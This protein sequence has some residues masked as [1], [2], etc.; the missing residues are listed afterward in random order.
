MANRELYPLT[1][2]PVYRGYPWGGD[3]IA[4]TYGRRDAPAVAAESWEI[5]DRDGGMS[6][7]R[8]GPLAGVTLRELVARLGSRLLGRGTACRLC[9]A[10]AGNTLKIPKL[11]AVLR[12]IR[13]KDI[14]RRKK[15][16]EPVSR[17]A[18][19]YNLTQRRV[20]QILAEHAH[21]A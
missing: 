13:K 1:F 4:R 11:D 8:E 19:H 2:A 18:R 12:Q 10:Y 3:R 5:A 14:L 9:R 7:V 20:M 21:A 6:V 16:G 15:N 17:L